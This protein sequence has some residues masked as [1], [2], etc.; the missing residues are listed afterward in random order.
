LDRILQAAS[1]AVEKDSG[2]GALQ[3]FARYHHALDFTGSFA[4][5]A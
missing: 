2:S 3:Q 4:D 1:V 5:G